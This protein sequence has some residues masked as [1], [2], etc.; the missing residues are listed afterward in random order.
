MRCS[1]RLARLH[2]IWSVDPHDEAHV[3]AHHWP[4]FALQPS[5]TTRHP[6]LGLPNPP[7]PPPGLFTGHPVSSH[8]LAAPL[9]RQGLPCSV[10]PL[11]TLPGH[12]HPDV[13]WQKCS[14]AGLLVPG[15]IVALR[16]RSHQRAKSCGCAEGLA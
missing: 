10:L 13:H 14:M 2:M 8:H 4:P 5:L 11:C 6:T 9:P 1:R 7:P 3:V 12:H 15:E 16:A